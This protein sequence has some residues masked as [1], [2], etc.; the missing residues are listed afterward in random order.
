MG[1]DGHQ[2]LPENEAKRTL[3]K[4]NGAVLEDLKKDWWRGGAS[5]KW[6]LGENVCVVIRR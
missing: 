2:Q 5:G 4:E 1:A 6:V 3:W